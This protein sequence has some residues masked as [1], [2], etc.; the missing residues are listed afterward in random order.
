MKSLSISARLWLPPLVVAGLLLL[1]E[2]GSVLHTRAE[3]DE[4][5]ADIASQLDKID[6]TTQWAGLTEAN[7]ARALA[8]LNSTDTGLGERLKPEIEATS[9]RIS[10]LQ[11]AVEASATASDEVAALARVGQARKVYIDLRKQLAAARSAGTEV[12]EAELSRL[13]EVL[14]TYI[15]AQRETVALH[16][17]HAD[18]IAETAAARQRQTVTVV[19]TTLLALSV[20]L[21]ISTALTAR[22]ILQPLHHALDTTHRIAGGDLSDPH[23]SVR[24]DEIGDLMRGLAHMTRSLRLLVQ[25]VRAGAVSMES[26]SAEIALGNADLSRRTEMTASSLQETAASMTQL[27]STVQH[28]TESAAQA[29][30]LVTSAAEAA[31]R[32]G[33]VVAQVVQNMDEITASSRRIGDI[34]GVIDGIAF[35]TNILALNAAV[36]AARAGEQGRGFAVVASE[37]RSLAQRSAEAAREIKVLIGASVTTVDQGAQLVREAGSTIHDLVA[38]VRHV[39]DIITHIAAAS[40]EQNQGIQQIGQ[41]LT[42]LEVATQQNAALVEQSAAAADSLRDESQRLNQVVQKFRIEANHIA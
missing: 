40:S 11:K 28:S 5:R 2:G 36:E 29:H 21:V 38:S 20:L 6:K 15:A 13:R 19:G 14:N 26:A 33:T 30:Q 8:V 35:Q 39:S 22:A 9:A 41:A 12:S 3:I 4:A 37:V 27:T 42:Q 25:D 16:Y 24:Q 17:R 23:T 32:G 34:T 1:V 7:A 10:A 31:T 18:A